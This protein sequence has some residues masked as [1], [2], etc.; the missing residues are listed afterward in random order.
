MW[1]PVRREDVSEVDVAG[2]NGVRGSA[3]QDI[4][5]H[6]DMWLVCLVTGNGWMF[7][8]EQRHPL[9]SSIMPCAPWQPRVEM[10]TLGVWAWEAVMAA[11]AEVVTSVQGLN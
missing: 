7:P 10:R 4:L 8:A 6:W 3:T 1:R 2:E 5:G 11:T 9:L